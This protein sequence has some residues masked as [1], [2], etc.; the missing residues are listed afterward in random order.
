MKKYLLLSLLFFIVISVY[1]QADFEKFK[2]EQIAQEQQYKEEQA[3]AFA[4]YYSMQ[5]SLFIKY[6]DKIEKLWN[7]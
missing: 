4:N 6:K 3:K 2:R 7:N 5:D 1:A